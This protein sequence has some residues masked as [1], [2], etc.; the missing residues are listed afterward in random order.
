MIKIEKLY[1]KYGAL[2][3]VDG[4]TLNIN[5]GETFAFLGLNG[6][7]KSTTINIL[8]SLIRKDS[9]IVSVGGYDLDK[10]NEKVKSIINLSPQETAVALNLTVRE[11]LDFI[12]GL[13]GVK[14]AENK[15][16]EIIERFSLRNKINS[17]AKNLSGGQKRRL[18]LAMAVITEPKVLI[19]DEPTLGLDV[20]SRNEL[21][22][23]IRELKGEV[24][25]L[26][27]THYLEEAV[28]LA[29]RIGVMSNGKLVI[30]GTAE[31]IIAKSGK[32]NFE[33][34]FLSLCGGNDD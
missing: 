11:N 4:L 25:I 10:E 27:T 22:K 8:C 9:G 13:Y 29:D 33:E 15:R 12:C 23:I 6:A 1:K 26:M 28:N 24:T 20:K 5:K 17:L 18:S 14:D 3:A 31:E 30:D 2:T 19:L 7:G 34:A 21:W 32:Q 16:N